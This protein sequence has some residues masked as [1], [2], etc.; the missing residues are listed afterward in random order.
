MCPPDDCLSTG[1]AGSLVSDKQP[2]ACGIDTLNADIGTTY[3]LTYVVRFFGG[4]GAP[5]LKDYL[6]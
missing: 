2:V 5:Y 1:C 6:A 4:G 3:T